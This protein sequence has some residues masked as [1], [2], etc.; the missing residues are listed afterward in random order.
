[1]P[2]FQSGYDPRGIFRNAHASTVIPSLLRRVP[3]L[4][5]LRERLD[6]LGH[7]VPLV[8]DFHFNGHRLLQQYP[9][10]AQALAK[11]RINPGNVG[12][13][14][15]R[16]SQFATMIEI[17]CRHERPVRIGVNWG[18]LDQELLTRLMDE[19]AASA[20]P[21]EAHEV[22]QEA[23]VRSALLSAELAE[24]AGLGHDRIILSAKVSGV[25]DLIDV[26]RRVDRP[27][28][29]LCYDPGN[30]VYYTRGEERPETHVAE[31]AERLLSG[32]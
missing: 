23:I 13:G 20:E 32:R 9:E 25:Q 29:G 22:L 4:P 30:I 27:G 11:Y 12:R 18:S 26:Y 16:D 7:R 19:N 21:V 2:L 8:G 15:K 14:E 1:M 5:Y 28:F 24:E 10:C 3:A 17:A 31:A 6:L